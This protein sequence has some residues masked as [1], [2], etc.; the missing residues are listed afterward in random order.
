MAES[1]DKEYNEYEKINNIVEFCDDSIS[2]KYIDYNKD[3]LRLITQ[4]GVPYDDK[5]IIGDRLFPVTVDII[6]RDTVPG[7]IVYTN[8]IKQLCIVY[9]GICPELEN[10]VTIPL[11]PEYSK[12]SKDTFMKIN[13]IIKDD[14]KNEIVIKFIGNYRIILPNEIHPFLADS[15]DI[16]K[17]EQWMYEWQFI[18]Y[19]KEVGN[20]ILRQKIPINYK[21]IFLNELSGDLIVKSINIKVCVGIVIAKEQKQIKI[22]LPFL[23]RIPFS[24]FLSSIDFPEKNDYFFATLAHSVRNYDDIKTG[25]IIT[26]T[27]FEDLNDSDKN[28]IHNVEKIS[29]LEVLAHVISFILYTKYL[30]IKHIKMIPISEYE[31][32][33]YV[34]LDQISDFCSYDDCNPNMFTPEFLLRSYLS[35]FFKQI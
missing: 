3:I 27:L 17:K 14:D 11:W 26:F 24:V 31:E 1:F 30:E 20:T 19:L 21:Q 22:R 29:S 33:F 2:D 6:N 9:Y 13:K 25:D 5:G 32:L 16:S 34:C 35:P 12:S 18:P 7:N 23:K 15:I 4:K 8:G 10:F 28:R